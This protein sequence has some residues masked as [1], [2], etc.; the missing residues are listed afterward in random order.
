VGQDEHSGRAAMLVYHGFVLRHE[1][2]AGIENA[3]V[4]PEPLSAISTA[5]L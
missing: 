1:G 3:R 5:S 2:A 4:F